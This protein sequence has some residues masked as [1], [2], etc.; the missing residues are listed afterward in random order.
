MIYF[1]MEKFLGHTGPLHQCDFYNN[2]DAGNRFA[3][4]LQMG[5]SRPWPEVIK[6]IT[7][8]PKM[9]ASAILEYF[10][11]L[12]EFLQIQNAGECFGW[13]ADWSPD[14]LGKLPQP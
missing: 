9:S 13:N 5:S 3:Q 8:Q 6:M 12:Y 14:V 2:F 1:C 4:M 10:R 7:G 11:P